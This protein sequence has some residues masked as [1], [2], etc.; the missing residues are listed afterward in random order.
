MPISYNKT[1]RGAKSNNEMNENQL[2]IQTLINQY[3]EE[4]DKLDELAEYF[5]ELLAEVTIKKDQI[6]QF[7]EDLE[8]LQD[9]LS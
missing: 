8:E 4:I 9:D 7:I 2:R 6:D 3:I 5:P 1:I